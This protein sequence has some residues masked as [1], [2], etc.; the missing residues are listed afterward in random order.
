MNRG[1][2]GLNVVYA[3]N[4]R[5]LNDEFYGVNFGDR[6]S[7]SFS[8]GLN[9]RNRTAVNALQYNVTLHTGTVLRVN[10]DMLRRPVT[11][12]TFPL[13]RQACQTRRESI[14]RH[15]A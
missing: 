7:H 3:Y 12:N 2:S 5:K 13:L 9:G 8:L 6:H 15:R 1:S 4:Y 11:D 14:I 10:I